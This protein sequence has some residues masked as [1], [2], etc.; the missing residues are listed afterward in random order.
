MET[1]RM[2]N[3]TPE[4]I[5]RA[6]ELALENCR[7]V[8]AREIRRHDAGKSSPLVTYAAWKHI[9][10]FCEEAGVTGSVLRERGEKEGR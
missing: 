10:R 2:S 3:P 7:M 8:A 4:E 1:N 9:L 6:K 5:S